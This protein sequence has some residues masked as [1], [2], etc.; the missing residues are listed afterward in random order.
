[1]MKFIREKVKTQYCSMEGKP[2]YN[3]DLVVLGSQIQDGKEKLRVIHVQIIENYL[4]RTVV[5]PLDYFKIN[6]IVVG[7][8]YD[9]MSEEEATDLVNDNYKVF[10]KLLRRACE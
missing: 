5:K 2:I 7:N 10:K 3:G 8:I 4:G 1:M 6:W 9:G